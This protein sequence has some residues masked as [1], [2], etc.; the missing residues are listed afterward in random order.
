MTKEIVQLCT[1]LLNLELL[2]QIKQQNPIYDFSKVMDEID[3]W[4][5]YTESIIDRETR[6]INSSSGDYLLREAYRL[7]ELGACLVRS[8]FYIRQ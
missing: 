3:L 4:E 5:K 7:A 1:N 6:V 2:A 8:R